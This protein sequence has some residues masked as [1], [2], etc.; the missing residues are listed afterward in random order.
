MITHEQVRN[1]QWYQA[2]VQITFV[3]WG[4][5]SD[6]NTPRSSFF[7]PL[8]GL[9]TQIEVIS[10]LKKGHLKPPS[11]CRNRK[12]LECFF[13]V[14]PKDLGPSNGR[15]WTCVAGVGSSKEPVLRVQ[16]SLG[17]PFFFFNGRLGNFQWSIKVLFV[18]EPIFTDS[19]TA[20]VTRFSWL[21]LLFPKDP[22]C[23]FYVGNYSTQSNRRVQ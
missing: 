14:N 20:A 8:P 11:L 21:R 2:F 5:L 9:I 17:K 7:H 1:F 13:L 22:G 15:G 6:M 19:S 4:G 18:H 12:N 16:W 23:L 10:P 3:G